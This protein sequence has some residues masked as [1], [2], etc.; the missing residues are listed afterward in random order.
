MSEKLTVI[1]FKE[2]NS[3]VAHCVELRL[4]SQGKTIEE[5]QANFKAALQLFPERFGP[6]GPG[7]DAKEIVFYPSGVIPLRWLWVGNSRTCLG[8]N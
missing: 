2:G 1:I 5:A 3:Y 4:M 7:K 6:A 8:L